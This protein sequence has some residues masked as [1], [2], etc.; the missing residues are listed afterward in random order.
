MKKELIFLGTCNACVTEC[1]NTCFVLD[2]GDE[3]ILVDGGGGVGV[4]RQLM[5][6][7]VAL[8]SIHHM[9]ISHVHTDHLFGAIWVLRT[10]IMGMH[11]G[12]YEAPL[13]VYANPEVMAAM[14]TIMGIVLPAL[15]TDKLGREVELVELSDGQRLEIIGMPFTFYE[16]SAGKFRQFGFSVEYEEGRRLVCLGDEP[17]REELSPVV[18]GADWLLCEAFCLFEDEQRFHAY[19]YEHGTAV[20]AA[21]MAKKYGVKNLVLYH[22]EDTDLAH[23][24][25]RYTREASCAFDGKVYVPDDLER[26]ILV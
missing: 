25:Q 2:T 7:D 11:E 9:F 14:K 26:I 23:R 6:A 8:E 1:Y 5:Q 10:I 22:T 13:R 24:K 19:E 17:F 3:R 15:Y 18:R 4:F 20:D 16:V 21:R 12:T